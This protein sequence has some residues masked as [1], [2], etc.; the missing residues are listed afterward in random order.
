MA[1]EQRMEATQKELRDVKAALDEH[2]IVAI[3]NA[4]GAITYANE[5]FCEISK[6]SLVELLGQNHRLINSS[7]H[8]KEFFTRLWRTI[9][10]G[11]VWR[12]EIKNRA[13]D[14]SFYWVDTTIV[15]FLNEAGKPVQYVSIRT[16]ITQ[17]K[18]LELEFLNLSDSEQRRIGRDLH[19]GLGQQLTAME[20]CALGLC[21]ELKVSHPEMVQTV[22]EL[23]RQLRL[24]VTQTRL[25]SRGLSTVSLEARGLMDALRELADSTR[26]LAKI[27][28]HF[29]CH[30]T[31]LVADID[32]A[33][34]LYRIAQEAVNNA[35]K[36]SET[37]AIAITLAL[38]KST[39]TLAIRDQGKGIP[40]AAKK[41][42]GMGL[43]VMKYRADLIGATLEMNSRARQGTE[44]ICR[45]KTNS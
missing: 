26:T 44:I 9:A 31:V 38:Q 15:P 13:K 21:Q 3:T 14:G 25:L 34:H 5:K 17:R 37:K 32:V 43:R 10:R 41:S 19:D 6:Y 35:V 1:L 24:A 40:A 27:D 42:S 30:T 4:A 2:S 16:D 28:C 36:H 18:R 7:Y 8:P 22:Q 39:L 11:E 23:A 33:T 20:L 29:T 12:G 45:V